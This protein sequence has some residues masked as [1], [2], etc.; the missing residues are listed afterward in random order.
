MA[1]N[2]RCWSNPVLCIDNTLHE[3]MLDEVSDS[4]RRTIAEDVWRRLQPTLRSERDARIAEL[5]AELEIV[6]D[7]T[8]TTEQ[9]RDEEQTWH[10]ADK[11][12]MA[13][14]VTLKARIAEL[15][16]HLSGA[17][18]ALVDAEK[19]RAEMFERIFA[20][21][22]AINEGIIARRERDA[23]I[24]ELEAEMEI[25]R[26]TWHAERRIWLVD[27][28][29]KPFDFDIEKMGKTIMHFG[30]SEPQKGEANDE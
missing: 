4:R 5:E 15:E 26:A 3:S 1:E 22:D 7:T 12:Q 8:W 19:E 2:E 6:R 29:D 21:H 25:M 10:D 24:A 13:E 16:M 18:A 17:N 28:A 27:M 14:I 20:Y 9:W 11:A 23:R 30:W